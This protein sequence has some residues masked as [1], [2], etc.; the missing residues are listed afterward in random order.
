MTP[1]NIPALGTFME[2][3]FYGGIINV[4]GTHKGVIWAPKQE[5]QIS[6]ILLPSK[7][8]VEGAGSPFDC[9]ANTQALLAAM[10]IASAAKSS[11]PKSIPAIGDK[12]PGTEATYAGVSLSLTGDS[13]VHLLLWDADAAISV[14]Y[15][16]AVAHAETVSPETG[17]HLPTRHQAITLF[18]NLRDRFDQDRW[19]WTLTKTKSGNAAFNQLFGY[20]YQFHDY[21]SSECRVRAVSE[22]PL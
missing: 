18:E 6:T 19:H 13:L 5:G 9:A 1:T 15:D 12:W 20:G 4:N 7:Q 17:S 21:L 10:A 16:A 11:A 14:V 3:G 8:T 2:G 22:I